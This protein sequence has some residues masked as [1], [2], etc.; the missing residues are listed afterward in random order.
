MRVSEWLCALDGVVLGS[1]YCVA[2][3][4]AVWRGVLHSAALVASFS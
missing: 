1:G 4:A 2:D 3:F